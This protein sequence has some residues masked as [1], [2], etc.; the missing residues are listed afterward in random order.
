[1]NSGVS[2]RESRRAMRVA[3]VLTGVTACAAAFTPAA[4]AQPAAGLTPQPELRPAAAQSIRTGN[5][6]NTPHWFHLYNDRFG[7]AYCIG[8]M[9]PKVFTHA[10]YSATAF[11]GGNNV[12]YFSGWR[13]GQQYTDQRFH[14][15]S[16]SY[17]WGISHSFAVSRVYLSA[18]TGNQSCN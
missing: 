15:S 9:G 13:S 16:N 8:G 5:C 10:P 1:M 6:L 3:T 14:Q 11:C 7:S 18:W 2:K 12:G 17:V 4:N